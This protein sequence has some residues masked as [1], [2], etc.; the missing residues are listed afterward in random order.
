MNEISSL[1]TI[2]C[3]FWGENR[4]CPHEFCVFPAQ[5]DYSPDPLTKKLIELR[6]K[7]WNFHPYATHTI[8]AMIWKLFSLSFYLFNIFFVWA[9]T[10][11]NELTPVV[12][13]KIH[14]QTY[15]GCLLIDNQFGPFQSTHFN[16]SRPFNPTLTVSVIV[17]ERK[18]THIDNKICSICV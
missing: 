17:C 16:E 10:K 7:N 14:T 18:T 8:Q 11:N 1:F 12:I 13:V 9:M 15:A 3:G 4:C 6:A 2:L 5:R